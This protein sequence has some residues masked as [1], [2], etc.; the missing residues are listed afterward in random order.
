MHIFGTDIDLNKNEALQLRVEN[1]IAFPSLV[2]GDAGYIFHHTGLGNFYGWDG[3]QWVNLSVPAG[4]T[5]ITGIQTQEE[6]VA[7]DT[8]VQT[9]N[10]V[11]SA[12]TATDLGSGVTQIEI[13]GTGGG[14]SHTVTDYRSSY[15]IVDGKIY[16]GYLLDTVITITREIN[17]VI[18]SATGLTNLETDWTN[19]LT[20]TYV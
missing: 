17:G 6:G 7:V 14:A 9:L 18:E 19:R 2:A 16:D 3:I 15:E 11:G 12:V 8:D 5:G 4:T 20:L 10:F 13:T 1:G